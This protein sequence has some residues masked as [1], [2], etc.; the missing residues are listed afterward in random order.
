MRMD[1]GMAVPLLMEVFGH[2]TQQQTFSYLGIQA[3]KMTEIY[4]LE[5]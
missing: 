3:D 5:L 1:Q 2:A 4:E